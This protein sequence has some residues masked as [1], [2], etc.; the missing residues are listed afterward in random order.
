[1]IRHHP[2]KGTK[3]KDPPPGPD[4]TKIIP[5]PLPYHIKKS[6]VNSNCFTNNTMHSERDTANKFVYIYTLISHD[7]SSF[8]WVNTAKQNI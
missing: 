2:K 8:N 7:S 3:K 5:L 4:Y 6:I 1:M